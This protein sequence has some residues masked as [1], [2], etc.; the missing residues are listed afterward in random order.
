MNLEIWFITNPRE[1]KWGLG[2]TEFFVFEMLDFL[3]DKNGTENGSQHQGLKMKARTLTQINIDK[4]IHNWSKWMA[5]NVKR[6][7]WIYIYGS[8]KEHILSLAQAGN[9]K[10]EINILKVWCVTKLAM[11]RGEGVLKVYPSFIGIRFKHFQ[12]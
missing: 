2:K 1:I 9:V 8:A 6:M 11:R 7:M 10:L 12:R 5:L 3:K 4:N